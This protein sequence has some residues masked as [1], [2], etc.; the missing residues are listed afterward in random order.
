MKSSVAYSP[1][2]LDDLDDIYEVREKLCSKTTNIIK[3]KNI[4]LN[5]KI[6]RISDIKRVKVNSCEFDW[7]QIE[8]DFERPNKAKNAVNL[9]DGE[10][11]F[12]H[13][14]N[15]KE[16]IIMLVLDKSDVLTHLI[17]QGVLQGREKFSYSW[18]ELIPKENFSYLIGWLFNFVIT[19][20][21]SI[22]R[23]ITEVPNFFLKEIEAYKY[24]NDEGK[25]H[26]R[27]SSNTGI[28]ECLETKHVLIND[29]EIHYIKISVQYDNISSEI[30]ISSSESQNF[31]IYYSDSIFINKVFGFNV[32]NE[33]M[34]LFLLNIFILPVLIEA[35][36]NDN[37][38][39][40]KQLE[41]KQ[42]LLDEFNDMINKHQ[43]E[44]KK[45]IKTI[46]TSIGK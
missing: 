14:K 18:K 34:L 6:N 23:V 38:N 29:N 15:K 44:I 39:K 1:Y 25:A 45:E 9:K 37:W 4:N 26:F 42:I 35:F 3:L 27:G 24:L 17:A 20:E 36:K 40:L 5:S 41:L 43:I 21:N 10:I 8:F 13:I 31:K 19:Y 46:K 30:V 32:E 2:I 7:F 16:K 33:N 12:Y 11:L 28:V 22:D